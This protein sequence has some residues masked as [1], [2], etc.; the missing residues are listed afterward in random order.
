MP[1][2]C[3]CLPGPPSPCPLPSTHTGGLLCLVFPPSFSVSHGGTPLTLCAPPLLFFV[4]SFPCAWQD[5]PYFLPIKS[6]SSLEQ[7]TAAAQPLAWHTQ[8]PC[9]QQPHLLNHQQPRY[10]DRHPNNYGQWQG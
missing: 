3:P 5:H 2:P 10:H 8:Q 4:Y 1:T 7:A 9:E 6:F